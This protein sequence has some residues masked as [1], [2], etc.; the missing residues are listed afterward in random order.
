MPVNPTPSY[1]DTQSTRPYL[2]DPTPYINFMCEIRS[3]RHLPIFYRIN[4][5][6]VIDEGYNFNKRLYM[7]FN[8]E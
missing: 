2:E 3:T 6:F 1:L 8:A 4:V 5:Y 7:M